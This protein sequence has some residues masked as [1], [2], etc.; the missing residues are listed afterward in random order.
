MLCD[1]L[2]EVRQCRVCEPVLPLGANPVI[3][4]HEEAR[5]LIIGQ[6]PGIRVHESSIPWNDPSGDRLRQWLNVD[7]ETFYDP[8]QIA[9]MPMGL[10]YPGKGKSGD[11]PPRKECAPQWHQKVL[12]QL[13]NIEITLLIGQYAQNYYLKD[14]PSTLTDTVRQWQR[15]APHYIPLP[16]PSPRNTLWL[17]KNPWFEDE[18]VTYIRQHFH[19]QLTAH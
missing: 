2:R 19:T 4:A 9:I 11:L 17:K 12:A 6:A 5:I 15:W 13:P 1:L 7:K 8:K 14:K 10:C 18:V 3:Q 16:H